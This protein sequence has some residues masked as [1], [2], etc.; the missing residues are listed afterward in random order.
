MK[1]RIKDIQDEQ[2]TIEWDKVEGVQEYCVYWSD[3]D[4]PTMQYRLTTQVSQT[5]YTLKKATHVPHFIKVPIQ[6]RMEIPCTV[7]F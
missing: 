2:V 3:K 4:T 1:L 6:T 5:Q 7:T